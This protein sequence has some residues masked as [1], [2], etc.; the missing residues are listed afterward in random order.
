M[1]PVAED[2][3]GTGAA[4]AGPMLDPTFGSAP[5]QL[6]MTIAKVAAQAQRSAMRTFFDAVC[7]GMKAHF[8]A[9]AQSQ[10]EAEIATSRNPGVRNTYI[11]NRA[12]ERGGRYR[13][14]GADSEGPLGYPSAGIA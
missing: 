12:I 9:Q 1:A 3:A 13:G 14:T 4:M 6:A 8:L 2:A 5:A 11:A 7:I 10:P